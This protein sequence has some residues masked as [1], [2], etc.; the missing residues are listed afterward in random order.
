MRF[1]FVLSLVLLFAVRGVAWPQVP[2]LVD[3]SIQP[4]SAGVAAADA[5][6]SGAW[7]NAAWYGSIPTALIAEQIADDGTAEVIY[8]RGAAEHPTVAAHW[9][10]LTGRIEGHCLTIQLPAPNSSAGFRV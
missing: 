5:A 1:C 9:L 10:R 6:F 8:A 4:P 3:F 2:L 7:G